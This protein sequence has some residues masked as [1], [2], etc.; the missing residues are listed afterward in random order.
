MKRMNENQTKFCKKCD[1]AINCKS[2]LGHLTS[3]KYTHKREFGFVV[4]QYEFNKPNI[5]EVNHIL[6]DVVEDCRNTFF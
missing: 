6:K 3:E 5:V 2:N 4:E 1:R